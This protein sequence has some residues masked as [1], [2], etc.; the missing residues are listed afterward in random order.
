MEWTG[1]AS[2]GV[3][4]GIEADKVT[5][6]CADERRVCETGQHVEGGGQHRR[7]SGNP[8]WP[9]DWSFLLDLFPGWD[10]IV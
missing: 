1:P 9:F 5:G 2:L 4:G 6:G 3:V 8:Q 10:L 7:V